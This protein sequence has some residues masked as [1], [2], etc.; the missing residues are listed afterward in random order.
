MSTGRVRHGS[1]L[2][3]GSTFAVLREVGSRQD[4]EQGDGFGSDCDCRNGLGGTTRD[5]AGVY[6]PQAPATPYPD[7]LDLRC[8]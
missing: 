4:H 1:S 7:S 8:A 2:L 5:T 3:R 6:D